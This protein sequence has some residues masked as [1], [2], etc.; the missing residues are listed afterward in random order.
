VSQAA[1]AYKEAVRLKHDF[2]EAHFSLAVALAEQRKWAEAMAAYKEAI[3]LKPD[4]AE[5]HCNLGHTLRDQGRFIEAL[6]PLRRGHALG[7]SRPDWLYPSR[8]WI[9]VC[10][11]LIELDRKLTAILDRDAEPASAA[12]RLALASL[13]QLPCKRLHAT[14]VRL[15][16]EAFAADPKLANDLQAPH[17]YNAACSAVLAATG[18]AE[19]ARFLPD[20]V[21]LKLR[22]QARQWLQ[23]DLTLYASLLQ[24]DPRFR[25]VVQQRLNHWQQDSDLA[26]VRDPKALAH[27]DDDER[28]QWQK[29]WQDVAALLARTR[30]GK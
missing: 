26:S 11:H 24:Q 29:L 7:I 20:K 2:P 12:E 16:S 14:A 21:V 8:A 10:Q 22:G 17:R 23:A 28:Q 13:C 4:Y 9:R 25:Q 6:G 27:M 5:A 30:R 3:R 15:A 18:Q 19:D 1:A